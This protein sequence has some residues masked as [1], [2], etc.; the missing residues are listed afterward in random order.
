MIVKGSEE[1]SGSLFEQ[2][3]ASGIGMVD[4]PI[5][6]IGNFIYNICEGWNMHDE[7]FHHAS[8]GCAQAQTFYQILS[9]RAP[10]SISISTC[11]TLPCMQ[12]QS[13]TSRVMHTS[14]LSSSRMP[15][16]TQSCPQTRTETHTEIG[17][18]TEAS[19]ISSISSTSTCTTHSTCSRQ[20][21]Q[22]NNTVQDIVHRSAQSGKGFFDYELLDDVQGDDT[23]FEGDA[24][25]NNS[26]A[27]AINQEDNTRVVCNRV[28]SDKFVGGEQGHNNNFQLLGGDCIKIRHG[29]GAGC[30]LAMMLRGCGD[31]FDTDTRGARAKGRLDRTLYFN[32]ADPHL[33]TQNLEIAAEEMQ[34]KLLALHIG[35]HEPKHKTKRRQTWHVTQRAPSAGEELRCNRDGWYDSIAIPGEDQQSNTDAPGS[36]EEYAEDVN[37]N[38]RWC[39]QGSCE[40]WKESTNKWQHQSNDCVHRRTH[41]AGE[42]VP[43]RDAFE[44]RVRK[45]LHIRKLLNGKSN[46]NNSTHGDGDP[47]KTALSKLQSL[48]VALATAM[49]AQGRL[50]VLTKPSLTSSRNTTASTHPQVLARRIRYI[51]ILQYV[52]QHKAQHLVPHLCTRIQHA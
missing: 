33:P 34:R 51:S 39:W 13:S 21:V 49:M 45:E 17:V 40:Q 42:R 27:G 7:R 50:Q 28:G 43:D 3:L 23:N 4:V 36:G 31:S 1:S 32:I 14:S 30:D 12:A 44:Q 19:S 5:G 2:E 41:P 48:M 22:Y 37:N 52:L 9:R 6:D 47:T 10:D 38:V 20:E 29:S 11:S 25:N 35:G 46:A 18:H 8:I 26:T 15:M 24:Y 16:Q